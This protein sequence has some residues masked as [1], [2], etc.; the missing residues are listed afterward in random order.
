MQSKLKKL[1]QTS[2]SKPTIYLLEVEVEFVKRKKKVR[3]KTWA[4]SVFDTVDDLNEFDNRTISRISKEMK[5]KNSRVT[6]V[7]VLSKKPL[8]KSTL[9]LDELKRQNRK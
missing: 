5:L 7:D 6:V 9:T 3:R 1:S 4:V 2:P 8:S